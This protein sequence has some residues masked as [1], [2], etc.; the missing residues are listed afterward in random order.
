MAGLLPLLI[1]LTIIETSVHSGPGDA[2][3]ALSLPSLLGLIGWATMLWWLSC[4]TMARTLVALPRLPRRGIERWDLAAQVLALLAFAWLCYGGGW[5]ARCSTYH[6]I[7]LAPWLAW[8]GIHWWCLS[9]PIRRASRVPWT[10]SAFVW[11]QI[12]FSLLPLAV[13]LPVIDLMFFIGNSTPIGGWFLHQLGTVGNVLAVF[14]VSA[15][16]LLLLPWILVRMWGAQPLP[17]SALRDELESACTRAR[18]PIAAILRWPVHGGRVYNAMVLGVLPRL[19]YVL[20]TD[21]LL[22]DFSSEERIAVLGHE[23]GHAR[24]GHL[25]IYMLFA[26]A[27]GLVSLL[28]RTPL[29]GL[30]AQVP[31][32]NAIAPD[33]RSGLIALILLALQWR[34]AFGYLSRACE[35]QADLAGA[36]LVGGGD[37]ARGAPQMQRALIAV[38]Q[39][40]GTDPQSPSWRH[41]SINQRVTWLGLVTLDAQVAERHHQ[42]LR[43]V[44]GLLAAATS[45]LFALSLPRFF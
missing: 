40:S 42:R 27:T 10:R 20:F 3:G 18:I 41:Y 23:L 39:F 6:S 28:A 16:L 25:W 35:R 4:E 2:L 13:S 33:V 45:V 19:R 12:R 15:G 30:F 21:D 37:T 9:V 38:A 32:A 7:A 24:H 44:V 22:R 5:G 34:L 26:L 14:I 29:E 11:Q 17:A 1:A 36:T 8:Q 31:R 43:W